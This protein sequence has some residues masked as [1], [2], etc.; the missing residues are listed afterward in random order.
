MSQFPAITVVSVFK[1]FNDPKF[2]H[3]ITPYLFK[4]PDGRKFKVNRIRRCIMQRV[5]DNRH[6]HYVLETDKKGK[7]FNIVF[8]TGDL[9]WRL[10]QEVPENL[11][12]DRH[13]ISS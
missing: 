10:I 1:G 13:E 12:F 2:E 6:Y 9:K 7:I 8:D 3:K 11:F 4:L 5:G